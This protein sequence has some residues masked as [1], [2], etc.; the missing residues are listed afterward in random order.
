GRL[1]DGRPLEGWEWRRRASD[2]E[3]DRYQVESLIGFDCSFCFRVVRRGENLANETRDVQRG[4][5][6]EKGRQ[7]DGFDGL[8]M[9]MILSCNERLV[10]GR[11][12]GSGS[13]FPSHVPLRLRWWPRR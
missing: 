6:R 10:P 4:G 13:W 11:K 12:D 9:V 2:A 3:V 7:C 8:L 1:S 5:A